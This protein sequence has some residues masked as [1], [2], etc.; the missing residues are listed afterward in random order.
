MG[1]LGHITELSIPDIY[2]YLRQ[3]HE[4]TAIAILLGI[5]IGTS[6]FVFAQLCDVTLSFFF[7][8]KNPKPK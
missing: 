3:R 6:Q 8:A 1:L 5:G 7:E 4:A 2:W